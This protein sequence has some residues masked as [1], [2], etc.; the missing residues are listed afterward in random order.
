MVVSLLMSYLP[1]LFKTSIFLEVLPVSN[2][3][4]AAYKTF[5]LPGENF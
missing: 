3:K 2:M 5:G 1:A 4:S